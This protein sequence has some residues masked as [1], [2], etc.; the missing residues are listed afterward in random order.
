MKEL[1]VIRAIKP[2]LRRHPWALAGMVILGVLEAVTEGLGISLF[3]PFLYSLDQQAIGS[4]D[5]GVLAQTLTGLFD[6]IPAADR[7][8]FIAASIFGLVLFKCSLSFGNGL[9]FS[10]VDARLSHTLRCRVVDQLLRVGVRFIER[11]KAGK[12]WNTLDSETWA[13]ANAVSTVVGL[14]ITGLTVLIFTSIL[15][16]ISW[17][18]TL[19]VAVALVLIST[20]VR[21][22]TRSIESM[23]RS[24]VRADESMSHRV[25][26]LFAGMRTI[27]AFGRERHER[28]R[29][30]EASSRVHRLGMKQ[31]WLTGLI[32]PVSEILAA[33]LLIGVLFTMLHGNQSNLPAVLVFIV[34]LYRLQPEVYGLD[35]GRVE[36][37]Q[38]LPAV[39]EVMGLLET[40]DKPYVRSGS[41]AFAGLDQAVELD[42]VS[43]RYDAQGQD[44]LTDLTLRIGKGETVALVGPSGAGKST[45]I[46]LLL[47]FYEPTAGAIRVDGTA[48]EELDLDSW[49][50]KIAVVSQDIHVFDT[51]VRENIAYGK[52]DATEEEIHAAARLADAD[53]FIAELPEGF[54]T[55]VGNQGVCLSGGQKQR[56]ALARALVR[57]PEI[58][59]LDE[60]TNAL[61]SLSENVIQASL[62][63]LRCDRTVIVIAHR[64]STIEQADQILVFNKG[65]IS[66]RGTLEDLLANNALFARLYSLQKSQNSLLAETA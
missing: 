43:F 45:L 49:R 61:D 28:R 42:A 23:A 53:T 22:M 60:A 48:I 16:L 50:E 37:V 34:V 57:D 25:I 13:A 29:Y 9:L 46:N 54:D 64:L 15:L 66:E 44:A 59:I 51:T 17:Q 36:L 33:G 4:T 12:L 3:I 24:S 63:K 56:I 26:E 47:R 10:W 20:M 18:L 7:L 41:V 8:M 40:A 52:L 65:R 31:E 32:E 11:A 21:R 38:Q 6:A 19:V 1:Q 5:G 30:A 39:E 2:L 55:R 58:L 62:Q 27:R 14:A 35:D